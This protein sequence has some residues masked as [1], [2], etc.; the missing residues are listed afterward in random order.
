MSSLPG[1]ISN[2]SPFLF[3]IHSL[4]RGTYSFLNMSGNALFLRNFKGKVGKIRRGV[5]LRKRYVIRSPLPPLTLSLLPTYHWERSNPGGA[6]DCFGTNV[7]RNDR[8]EV[9]LRP[10]L[11][12]LRAEGAAILAKQN[13]KGKM[14]EQK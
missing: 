3:P 7:P 13:S 12:S 8:R 14:T 9:S 2:K 1:S 10:F 6:S 5:P 11:L 4:Q